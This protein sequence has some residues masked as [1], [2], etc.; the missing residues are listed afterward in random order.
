MKKLTLDETWRLCLSMWRWIA[1]Q[2]RGGSKRNID[3]LKIQWLDIHGYKLN[4]DNEYIKLNCF[5][6]EYDEQQL[7]KE[8]SANCDCCPGKKIDIEFACTASGYCWSNDSIAFY[9]MLVSLNRKRLA[10]RKK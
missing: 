4:E 10:K 3:N 9:N 6:C 2:K 1:K 5:F 8:E 7:R